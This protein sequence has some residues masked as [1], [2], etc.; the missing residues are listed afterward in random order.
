MSGLILALA[1][2]HFFVIVAF[3][4]K[5]SIDTHIFV[6]A[7]NRILSGDVP[8]IDFY[9]VTLPAVQ[10]LHV[11]AAALGKALGINGASVW[12][13]LTWLQLLACLALCSRLASMA[14]GHR[15]AQ[16]YQ[17]LIPLLLAGLSFS[18]LL[19]HDFGQ[20]EH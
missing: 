11:P 9:L 12:L 7:A 3:P 20:R 17:L 5:S 8:Y 10:Y 15:A 4:L 6:A 16:Y 13:L 14:F 1:I 19:T 18:L 2:F